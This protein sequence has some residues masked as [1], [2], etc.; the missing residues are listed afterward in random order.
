MMCQEGAACHCFYIIFRLLNVLLHTFS[1]WRTT[2]GSETTMNALGPNASL[3]TPPLSRNLHNCTTE[4][5]NT[6]VTVVGIAYERHLD[7]PLK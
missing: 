4:V 2:T 1:K 3:Y 6:S 5:S 7:L